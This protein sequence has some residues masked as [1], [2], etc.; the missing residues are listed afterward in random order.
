MAENSRFQEAHISTGS[1]YLVFCSIPT[2]ESCLTTL[3][4][5]YSILL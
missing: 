2:M 5:D 3:E 4:M 1:Y